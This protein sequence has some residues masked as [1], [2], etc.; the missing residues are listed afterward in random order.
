MLGELIT[1]GQMESAG[2]RI[3]YCPK[4]LSKMGFVDI[5]GYKVYP[6]RSMTF[7]KPA[8]GPETDFAPE[9]LLKAAALI[10]LIIWEYFLP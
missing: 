8:I 9:K 6:R 7:F 2:P 5:W 4:R 1:L 10:N 3:L